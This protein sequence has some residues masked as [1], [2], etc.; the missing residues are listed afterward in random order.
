MGSGL[1]YVDVALASKYHKLTESC[2]RDTQESVLGTHGDTV[3][4]IAWAPG[5]GRSYH[6]IATASR[7]SK[8]QVIMSSHLLSDRLL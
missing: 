1:R 3:H 7:E 4:D 5:M 8:F 6:L 2:F